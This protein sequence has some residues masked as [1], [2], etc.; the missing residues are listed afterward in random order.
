MIVL[1][2][3]TD[4][5]KENFEWEGKGLLNRDPTN[6]IEFGD[7]TLNC[8]ER[9]SSDFV[10]IHQNDI[11]LGYMALNKINFYISGF[12]EGDEQRSIFAYVPHM[13]LEPELRGRGIGPRLYRW[14]NEQV[15]LVSNY[16]HSRMASGMWHKL[17]KTQ[18]TQVLYSENLDDNSHAMELKHDINPQDIMLEP[19]Y[20]VMLNYKPKAKNA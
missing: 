5:S 15:P 4:K 3:L 1:D 17:I 18:P 7:L 10:L 2:N 9:Y 6:V 11:P 14:V 16:R 13:H 19:G 8:Y 12:Q 20:H